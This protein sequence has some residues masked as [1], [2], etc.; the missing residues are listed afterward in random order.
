M[1]SEDN[2]TTFPAIAKIMNA[3]KPAYLHVMD[4]LGFGY[5]NKAPVVTVPDFR[6]VFDGPIFCNIALTRDVAEGMLRSGACDMAVFGRL[7]ISNPDLVA[8][9]ENDWPLADS[10]PHETWW[11]PTGAKGY[12]DW[13]TYEQ[14]QEAKKATESQAGPEEAEVAA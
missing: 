7:Y 8:R 14:E 4:G 12:T 9:F 13:P 5:H 10:P 2:H 3:Y 6:K 1:G 11:Y